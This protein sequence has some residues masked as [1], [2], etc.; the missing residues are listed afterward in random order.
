M[1]RPDNS[2]PIIT[3]GEVDITKFPKLENLSHENWEAYGTTKFTFYLPKK[4]QLALDE[5][6]IKWQKY[7][8]T[9]ANIDFGKPVKSCILEQIGGM[10]D[11][12]LESHLRRYRCNKD[13]FGY[14]FEQILDLQPNFDD[15]YDEVKNRQH[16]ESHNEFMLA[17][18]GLSQE[19]YTEMQSAEIKVDKFSES[20]SEQN[21]RNEIMLQNLLRDIRGVAHL[22]GELD[23]YQGLAWLSVD[24]NRKFKEED[25]TRRDNEAL[26][27][28]PYNPQNDINRITFR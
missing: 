3:L 22:R 19:E 7:K 1:P 28:I 10:D 26:K 14:V 20:L 25:R 23:V 15:G 6:E 2:Q 27:S 16:A 5:S 17:Y 24:E 13:Q 18:F 21:N 11:E 12:I 4:M 8:P 9:M